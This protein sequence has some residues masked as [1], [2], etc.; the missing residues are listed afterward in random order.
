MVDEKAI[1]IIPKVRAMSLIHENP[2]DSFNI[3]DLNVSNLLLDF[4]SCTFFSPSND[5]NNFSFV[6]FAERCSKS[7][8]LISQLEV[9]ILVGRVIDDSSSISFTW[10]IF[11]LMT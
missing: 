4:S 6:L 9:K 7:I 8:P 5:G 10:I 3:I 1:M 11:M 2:I